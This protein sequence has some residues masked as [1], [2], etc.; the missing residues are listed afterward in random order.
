DCLVE[1]AGNLP[2]CLGSRLTGAGFG[3]CTVSLVAADHAV[4]FI[5]S[6]V[7]GYQRSMGR[8]ARVVLCRPSDGVRVEKLK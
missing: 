3:G 6:L 8:E 5:E 1:I 4:S 7:E 2:G